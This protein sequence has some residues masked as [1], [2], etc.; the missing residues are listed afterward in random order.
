M[1]TLFAKNV[2]QLWIKIPKKMSINVM[3]IL[4]KKKQKLL[5]IL[6]KIKICENVL[7]VIILLLE[8]EENAII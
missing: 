1:V 2:L 6:K 4:L 7:I 8:K 3:K 5:N